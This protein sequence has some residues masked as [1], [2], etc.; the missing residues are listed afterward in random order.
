MARRAGAAIEKAHK[1]VIS[2]TM[3]P[4]ICGVSPWESPYT[5]WRR[6]KGLEP[7]REQTLPMWLGNQME[8]IVARL[9]TRETGMKVKRPGRVFDPNFWYTTEEYGFPMGCLLDGV[10]PAHGPFCVWEG[11]TASA[12]QAGEWADELPLGYYFQVQHQLAVTGYARCYVAALIGGN[13]F[14][15]PVVERDNEVIAMITDKERDFWF[16]H[17]MA[18]VPPDADGHEAT[19]NAIR[20]QWAHSTPDYSEVID[21]PEVER[22]AQVY[23]AQG[24]SI[25]TLE[26]ER[27]ATGNQLR[28]VLEDRESVV[29]GAYKISAKEQT[30]RRLD[31][32]AL[33][34]AHVEIAERFMKE[35]SSR[36]LRVTERK[37]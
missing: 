35:T 9:F 24:Q 32:T 36:P 27:D 11:K 28:L 12:W 2:A 7:P 1:D 3:A 23:V 30:A 15:H 14:K 19:S 37:T 33:K 29:S 16:K 20:A 34:A 18:N 4:I 25:K 8:P 13:I 10:T 6:I 21:D 22:L 5:L 26:N 17:V 31:T